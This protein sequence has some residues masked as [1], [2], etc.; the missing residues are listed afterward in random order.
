MTTKQD[1]LETFEH[2]SHDLVVQAKGIQVRSDPQFE[3]AGEFLL[4]VKKLN[5][6][7]TNHHEPMRKKSYAAYQEVLSSKQRLLDPIKKAEAIVKEAMGAFA[8][9][10]AAK[11][12]RIAERI[13][14]GKPGQVREEPKVQGV[15]TR[16]V[17]T[18]EV[19]SQSKITPDFM[20]PDHA[21]IRE[22]VGA[23]GEDA[24][25]I[26]GG[27]RVFQETKIAASRGA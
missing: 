5:S 27:I 22:L 11:Q 2:E 1:K 4:A 13:M 24:A 19:V 12:A 15:S 14:E 6:E 10:R 21:A 20:Q 17:W 18:Y 8:A 7:I 3:A 25:E 26:V 16:Q 23:L 9:L